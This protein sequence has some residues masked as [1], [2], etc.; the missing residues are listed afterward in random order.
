MDP[1][2]ESAEI[3][4]GTS[5]SAALAPVQQ[6]AEESSSTTLNLSYSLGAFPASSMN[7]LASTG[8]R[9]HTTSRPDL[10]SCG[11]ISRETAEEYF[12]FYM[13]N[14]DPCVH[15]IL[16]ENDSLATVRARSSLLTASICTVASFCTSSKDYQNCVNVFTSEVSRKLFSD[17]YEFDDVRALCIGAFWLNDISSALNGLGKY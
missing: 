2:Q 14:L 7:S 6:V 16:Q 12:D 15:H 8:E 17:K 3:A 5:E 11:L 10:I 13:Q 1:R 4:V 9:I